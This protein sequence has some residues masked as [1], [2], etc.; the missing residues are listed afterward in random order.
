MQVYVRDLTR[1][2][3]AE[4]AFYDGDDSESSFR[5]VAVDD[6]AQNV[7]AFERISA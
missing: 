5:R 3:V 4:P 1:F 6:A 7:F 2:Y